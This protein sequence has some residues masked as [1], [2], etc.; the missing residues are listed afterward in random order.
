MTVRPRTTFLSRMM[1]AHLC[2]NRIRRRTRSRLAW[3]LLRLAPGERRLGRPSGSG[4]STLLA[5]LAGLDHPSSGSISLWDGLGDAI[6]QCP[7][8]L[9]RPALGLCLSKP[10]LTAA[11]NRHRKCQRATRTHRCARHRGRQRAAAMLEQVGLA[12]HRPLKCPAANNN[13]LPLPVPWQA[14]RPCSGR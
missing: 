11:F 12:K 1:Y 13:A 4:K 6:S 3:L 2:P 14:A 7:G 8:P 9:P 10:S 5:L